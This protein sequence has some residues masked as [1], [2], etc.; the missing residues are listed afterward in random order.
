MNN[1]LIIYPQS[2]PSDLIINQ[3]CF[4][5]TDEVSTAFDVFSDIVIADVL[6]LSNKKDL[7]IITSFYIETV[8]LASK[9]IS[10]EKFEVSQI[11]NNRL[12]FKESLTKGVN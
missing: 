5:S 2:H 8:D 10:V 7:H 1:E 6:A 11:P 3:E 12:S 9:K 4:I